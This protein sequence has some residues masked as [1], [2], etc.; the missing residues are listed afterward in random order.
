M[1]CL[2]VYH[3]SSPEL[4]NKV[5]TYLED[6]AA[7]LSEHGVRFER[8]QASAPI[9][10]GASPQ[11]V[12][13]AYREPIERLKR[14]CG[15]QAVDVIS[16]SRDHPDKAELRQ[17]FLDEHCHSEDEVRFFVAGRGLFNLHLGDHVYAVLCEKGDLIS[18][19][20]GTPHWFDMGENPHFVAIRLFTDPEGWSA[21]MTGESIAR[22]FPLLED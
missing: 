7:T 22:R 10:P 9:V 21:Q 13:E 20:A 6:I 5:L 16:V 8:W 18:V 1:S 4:P 19:P 11:A 14:E 15:Y 17:K 3:Q 12:I 2:S